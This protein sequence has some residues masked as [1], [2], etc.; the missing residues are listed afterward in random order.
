M[1]P[2]AVIVTHATSFVV[3]CGAFGTDDPPATTKNRLVG[4][5]D[6]LCSGESLCCV[7]LYGGPER[8]EEVVEACRGPAEI[9]MH[10]DDASDCG[11]NLVCCMSIVSSRGDG[12]TCVAECPADSTHRQL[13]KERAEC[14]ASTPECVSFNDAAP[15]ILWP[16]NILAC[17]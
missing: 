15:G 4:C 8:C 16:F 5:S 1:W 7:D 3:A 13:C 9:V 10:C 6:S 12:S 17:K 11:P 2:R 14:H